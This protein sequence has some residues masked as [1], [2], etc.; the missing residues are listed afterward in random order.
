[1]DA[2]T[3]R[4]AFRVECAVVDG[5]SSVSFS[6]FFDPS[7]TLAQKDAIIDELMAVGERQ[8]AKNI[9]LAVQAERDANARVL[10][11]EKERMGKVLA[12]ADAQKANGGMQDATAQA[13]RASQQNVQRLENEVLKSDAKLEAL[14][15][16]LREAAPPTGS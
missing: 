14:K 6:G 3:D 2:V 1:M 7:A 11:Q 8:R 15:P 13:L 9:M 5:A 4:I 16:M 12:D 10:Q